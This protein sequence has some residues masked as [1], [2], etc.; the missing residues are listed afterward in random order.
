[1]SA[2]LS[3]A[4]FRTPLRVRIT[5]AATASIAGILAALSMLVYGR[6]QAQLLSAI[7][8]GLQAR[9]EAI[10]A[11]IGLPRSARQAVADGPDGRFSAPV[12]LVTPLGRVIVQSRP[13]L[14]AVPRHDLRHLRK[15]LVTDLTGPRPR[16]APMR[17]YL[18]PVNEGRALVVVAGPRLPAWRKP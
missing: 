10:A 2:S 15:P 3:R 16:A 17:V 14:P 6:V 13:D 18:L 12:E 7:D 8:S 11:S 5:A 9:A 4:L 1:M